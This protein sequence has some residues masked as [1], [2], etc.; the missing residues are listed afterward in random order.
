[1]ILDVLIR[2]CISLITKAFDESYEIHMNNAIIFCLIFFT[3]IDL[4]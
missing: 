1:M 4:G 3:Y 2:T